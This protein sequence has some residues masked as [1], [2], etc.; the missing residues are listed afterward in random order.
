MPIN[1]LKSESGKLKFYQLIANCN[2]IDKLN[3]HFKRLPKPWPQK[4]KNLK[5][6]SE[7]RILSEQAGINLITAKNHRN[8]N[9]ITTYIYI[10]FSEELD[11]VKVSK[12]LNINPSWEF[13]DNRLKID[14]NKLNTN[15]LLDIK[16]TIILFI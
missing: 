14:I 4:V 12:L 11:Y 6:I 3:D 16:N 5:E 2:S 9:E 13:K 8:L 10:H 1:F 7:L 15:W